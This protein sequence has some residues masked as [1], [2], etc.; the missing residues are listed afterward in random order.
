VQPVRRCPLSTRLFGAALF[1]FRQRTVV[2]GNHNKSLAHVGIGC[3]TRQL[4]ILRRPIPIG[5][6]S[7][8]AQE[9]LARSRL[10]SPIMVQH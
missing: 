3:Q 7:R 10:L 4:A 8:P 1:R 5:V 2:L 9:K 6:R